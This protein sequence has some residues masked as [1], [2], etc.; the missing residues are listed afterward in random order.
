MAE[1]V[2]ALAGHRGPPR[3][4]QELLGRQALQAGLEL[5][6]VAAA[7]RGQGAHPADPAQHRQVLQRGL[8]LG[9]QGVQACRDD[10]VDGL[11]QGQPGRAGSGVAHGEQVAVA[12]H[13]HVLL[14]ELGVAAG[15]GHQGRADA[16][17]ETVGAQQG[18]QQMAG[19]GLR[20]RLQLDGHGLLAAP[21]PARPAGQEVP[22]GGGHH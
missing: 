3:P 18:L 22:A 20:Q 8:L 5:G 14:G 2:L 12:H 7:D 10:G 17:G 9:R 21:A 19:V 11:G 4:V 13:A 1:A 16:G 6:P 15:R